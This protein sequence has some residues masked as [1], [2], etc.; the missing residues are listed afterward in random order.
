MRGTSS[1]AIA[2]AMIANPP[3]ST[4]ARS[5]FTPASCRRDMRPAPIIRLRRRA[6]PSGVMPPADSPFSSRIAASASAV[7]D[8]ANASCQCSRPNARAIAS[9]SAR[10]WVSAAA[11]ASARRLPSPKKRAD[12]LT[13]P[14]LSD[15][16]R[17][18]VMWR[19]MMNSVDP[20]PM[21]MTSRGL[22]DA[23]STCATPR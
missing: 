16:R 22:L 4:G 17:S 15:S 20:P 23:G 5:G 11:N 18:G 21:S 3:A 12:M 13:Q 7:P 14:S 19:P 1:S 6:R 2:A 10:A 9:I 8:D